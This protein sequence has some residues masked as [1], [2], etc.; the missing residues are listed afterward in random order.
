M[1]E[2][3]CLRVCRRES[4]T[5]ERE[6]GECDEKECERRESVRGVLVRV[7]IVRRESVLE[8]RLYK[9]QRVLEKRESV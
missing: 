9:N 6:Q 1:F 8:G 4:V 5:R 7:Q 3:L 2:S